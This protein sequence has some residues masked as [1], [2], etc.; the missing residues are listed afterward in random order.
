MKA[1]KALKRLAHVE[2]LLSDV[3]ERYSEVE[4]AV[5]QQLLDAKAAVS[6]AKDALSSQVPSRTKSAPKT[7][8]KKKVVKARRV[9][10]AK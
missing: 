3:T 2:D 6:R 5:R 4:P 9:K 10:A 8:G 1:T 7:V